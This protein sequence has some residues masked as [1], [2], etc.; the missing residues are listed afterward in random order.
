[1]KNIV[2]MGLIAVLLSPVAKTDTLMSQTMD[3]IGT[4]YGFLEQC[5]ER[6][7]IPRTDIHNKNWKAMEER[8]VPMVDLVFSQ[9]QLGSQGRV[10]ELGS[11]QW[12][13][14]Q[15]NKSMCSF[16]ENEQKKLAISIS[17]N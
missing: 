11:G 12:K 5:Y 7:L 16:A 6:G 10:F 8:G 14:Y 4:F 13:T 2:A 9:T 3:F 15:F 1:M 17:R